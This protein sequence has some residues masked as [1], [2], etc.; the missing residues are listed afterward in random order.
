MPPIGGAALGL[1]TPPEPDAAGGEQ[2]NV[3][4]DGCCNAI[5]ERGGT[6]VSI[7]L[8]NEVPVP[9]KHTVN[10]LS[11]ASSPGGRYYTDL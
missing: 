3:W 5:L 6:A 9:I 1:C 2:V 7:W 4:D 11:A 10:V 8:G